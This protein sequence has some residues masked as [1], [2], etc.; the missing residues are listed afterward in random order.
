M[1]GA[2]APS[3][4]NMTWRSIALHEIGHIIGLAHSSVAGAVMFPTVSPNSTNRVLQPDDI[5]GAR[6]LYPIQ[7]PLFVRHSGRCLDIEGISTDNGADA[8]QWEYWGGQNQV[9]RIEWVEAS[10]YR[11]IAQHSS[12]VID[13]EGMSPANGA[14]LHQW[15]WWGGDNQK[16]RL[17]P[18]GHGYYVLAAKHSGR[19]ADVAGIE[20]G[21]GPR[22]IQWDWWGGHNQ[23]WRARPGGHRGPALRQVPGC[24]RD[25]RRQRSALHPV[26]LL[27]RSQ[28]APPSRSRGRRLLPDH[29]RAVRQVPGRRGHLDRQ[30][31]AASSSGSTGAA[32]TRSSVRSRPAT[33]TADWWPS[34]AARWST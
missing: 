1:P 25:L 29:G 34:T 10:H 13:V 16:F 7:G 14:Q 20:V 31:R 2:S 21:N 26:A 9:F 22:I 24:R 33:G 11:L 3:R 8:I 23:Q 5:E 32:T 18:V 30:R 27:G 19:C 4:T 15:D 17:D 12:R 6:R 28:P